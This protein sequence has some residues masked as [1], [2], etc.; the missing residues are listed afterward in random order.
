MKIAMSHCRSSIG[1]YVRNCA[2]ITNTMVYVATSRCSKSV[3][4]HTERAWQYWLSRRSHTGHINWQK[5]EGA[6]RQKLPL[7]KPRIIHNI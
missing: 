4:E 2:A 5:F 7:P 1:R 6:V 3:F